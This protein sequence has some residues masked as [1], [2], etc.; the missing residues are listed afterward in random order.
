MSQELMKVSNHIEEC[1]QSLSTE[2]LNPAKLFNLTIQTIEYLDK[3]Y[4]TFTGE[5]K[6]ELLIEAFNDLCDEAKHES[7]TLEIRMTIKNFINEDLETVIESV[8]Q[9]SNGNFRINEKQQALL[10][11][12]IIKLCQ[13]MVKKHNE[14]VERP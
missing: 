7:L 3:E 14:K 10:I 2:N 12:C 5:Q 1:I 6:K 9:L 13:C 11:R 8:I 4:K